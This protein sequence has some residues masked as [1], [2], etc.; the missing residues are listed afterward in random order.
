MNVN[1]RFAI[2]PSLPFFL[3]FCLFTV[4]HPVSSQISVQGFIRDQETKKP[5]AAANIQIAGSYRGTISNEDGKFR[6]ELLKLPD[7]LNISYIGYETRQEVITEIPEAELNIYLK[8]I[9][10]ELPPIIVVAEDPAIDIMRQVIKRKKIWYKSLKTYR[11]DAYSRLVLENDSGIVSIAESISETFWDWQK[12]PRE[13]IKSKKQ[14]SNL[15]EDI[16]I[17]FASY[18]PNFYDDDI[19]EMGYKVIGPTHPDALKYYDFKLE[20]IRYLDNQDVFT[21]RVIPTTKLQPTFEGTIEVIDGAFALLA[22]DLHPS[23]SIL[24]PWPIQE[25]NLK[26]QQQFSNFGRVYWLPVDYRAEGSIKIGL[27]GLQFPTIFYKRITALTDYKINT[28]LPDSLY[29]QKDFLSVDSI[30]LK[31]PALFSKRKEI[32]PLVKREEEAYLKLDSTMTLSKAFKP[33]GFLARMVEVRVEEDRNRGAKGGKSE[34][35]FSYFNPQL[36]FN[37]VEGLHSGLN[38]TPFLKEPVKITLSAG[39]KTALKRGAFG[40]GVE[41][42]LEKILP[43]NFKLVY[44][45]NTDMRDGGSQTYSRTIS[46]VAPLLAADDYFDY[47]WNKSFQLESGLAIEKLNSMVIVR[48]KSELHSSVA[49]QTDFNLLGSDH[50]QRPNPAIEAGRLK[51]LEL[52]VNFGDAYIPFGMVGQTRI[53]FGLEYSSPR[54]FANDFDYTRYQLNADLHLNTFLKRRLLPIALDIHLAAGS[55]RGK[56]P[57]QKWYSIDGRLLGFSPFAVLRTLSSR[58]YE[59]E[60]YVAVFI[61]HNLRTVLFELLGWDYLTKN[62][63]G[64]IVHG[65]AGRTWISRERLETLPYPVQY[66]DHFH[67]EIGLSVNGL[68]NLFR[69]DISQRLDKKETVIG[70]GLSRF[71]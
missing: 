8:P 44:S 21:I 56:L 7:T 31:D 47:Y 46:S 12:G 45:S 14:T 41:Y 48:F 61:E 43:V 26:Y 54:L 18:I 4:S 3:F 13:V 59:G 6:V 66:I 15:S 20:K 27:T 64:I 39:Y 29:Q 40:G 67:Q 10:I 33:S 65:A 23:A 11:A 68:F 1:K 32:V 55:A 17:A 34:K 63:I 28:T 16:T 37:R 52:G 69:F 5:L 53:E 38:F 57:L 62:G 60:K 50:K 42:Q 49:K 51:S 70:F 22:V 2:H 25:W 36:W 35:F 9:L 71:F 58:P 24:Y 30:T 19:D